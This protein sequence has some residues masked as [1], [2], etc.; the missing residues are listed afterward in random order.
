MEQLEQALFYLWSVLRLAFPIAFL[1]TC[2]I[3]VIAIIGAFVSVFVDMPKNW[4]S[5][6]GGNSKDGKK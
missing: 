5:P 1:L 4:N 6:K 3:F 2:S